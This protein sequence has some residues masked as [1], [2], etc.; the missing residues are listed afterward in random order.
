M[1]FFSEEKL[2][3][4][5]KIGEY[6]KKVCNE[7]ESA[8]SELKRFNW[9]TTGRPRKEVDQPKLLSAIVRVVEASSAA[10]DRRPCEHLRS[11]KTLDDLHSEPKR[12]GFDLSRSAAYLRLLPRRAD[13]REGKPHV[14]NVKVKLVRPE[15]SLRKK[16]SD[17]MFAKSFMDDLLDVCE[18]FGPSSVLVLSIVDK[19]RVKLGLAAASLQSP[20]LMNMDYKVRLPGH[21]FVVGERHSLIPSVYGVFDV[22]EK[23]G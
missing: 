18:L 21:S 22:N 5:R 15:N 14:Q 12:L 7:N 16:N 2:Q 3:K 6:N 23:D 4:S 13:S 20:V 10:E 9:K 19:A 8:A 17:R 11:V 1:K